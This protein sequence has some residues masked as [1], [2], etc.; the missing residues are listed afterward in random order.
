[1][2]LSRYRKKNLYD[3]WIWNDRSF[4]WP[5]TLWNEKR[6]WNYGIIA[7]GNRFSRRKWVSNNRFLIELRP[8]N[9]T[10]ACNEFAHSVR[11]DVSN[12]ARPYINKHHA[13]KFHIFVHWNYRCSNKQLA[14]R[15]PV[16]DSQIE[17][18]TQ[19]KTML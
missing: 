15:L 1:M 2:K 14:D 4:Y 10:E 12:S 17:L 16:V 3:F 7:S 19:L 6:W 5:E 11:I 8:R 13:R 18:S 9:P